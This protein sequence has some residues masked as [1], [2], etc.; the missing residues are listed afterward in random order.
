M[1]LLMLVSREDFG[2]MGLMLMCDV[3]IGGTDNFCTDVLDS[4]GKLL[5]PNMKTMDINMTGCIYTVKLGVHYIRK[6]GDEGGSV[7]MTASG[8]SKCFHLLSLSM[9]TRRL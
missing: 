7:V 2:G 1:S 4:N 5:P 6:N 9:L 3:G 8:S